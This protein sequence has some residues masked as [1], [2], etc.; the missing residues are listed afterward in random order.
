MGPTI[1]NMFL[2]MIVFTVI[3]YTFTCQKKKK[4]T[5]LGVGG[6]RVPKLKQSKQTNKTKELWP[7]AGNHWNLEMNTEQMTNHRYLLP[8]GNV[9]HTAMEKLAIQN[10]SRCFALS[11]CPCELSA[12]GGPSQFSPCPQ[13]T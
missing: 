13:Q 11:H 1:S 12:V 3:E 6:I 2:S 8:P 4:Q 5:L 10:R 7:T 9:L